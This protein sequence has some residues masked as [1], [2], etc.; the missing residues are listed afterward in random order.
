MKRLS[1]SVVGN[2]D[3]LAPFAVAAADRDEI[4]SAEAIAG[5][6][7]LHDDNHVPAWP[8]AGLKSIDQSLEPR[9]GA[10]HRRLVVAA[11]GI[12]ADIGM[13]SGGKVGNEVLL[14]LGIDE[15]RGHVL[16]FVSSRIRQVQVTASLPFSINA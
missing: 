13:L 9:G 6:I 3:R 12:V 11:Q 8:L 10:D 5:V 16:P 14:A 4:I 7:H 2:V 15:K 1:A